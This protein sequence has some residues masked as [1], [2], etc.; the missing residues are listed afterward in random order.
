MKINIDNVHSYVNHLNTIKKLSG[1]ENDYDAANIYQQLCRLESK[2]H[3]LAEIACNTGE[4]TE[5]QDEKILN[6]V[7]QLLPYA[8]DI[9]INGD[10]RGYALKVRSEEAKRLRDSDNINI[11]QDFG[12]YGI[13]APEF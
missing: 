5:D 12:G 10:P 13:L 2:A 9:F 11:Y 3:R 6:R 8:K 7:K 1:A 4:D